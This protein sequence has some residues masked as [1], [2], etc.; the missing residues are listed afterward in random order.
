MDIETLEKQK[1]EM[2]SKLLNNKN[3]DE[4]K[5]LFAE[6]SRL[7]NKIEYY[8]DQDLK[9]MNLQEV[10]NI[11]K[12]TTTNSMIK[13]IIYKTKQKIIIFCESFSFYLY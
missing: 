10:K 12:Y 8:N 3:T 5:T 9:I 6:Y 13:N 4:R 1:Y 11:A 2:L 7:H